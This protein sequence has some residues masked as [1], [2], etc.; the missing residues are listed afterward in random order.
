[1]DQP[2]PEVFHDLAAYSALASQSAPFD[3]MEKAIVAFAD[4]A[5]PSGERSHVGWVLVR[6]YPLTPAL[7][8]VT[9]VWARPDDERYVVAAKGAP[10]AI[11]EMCHLGTTTTTTYSG[12]A[13]ILDA[14]NTSNGYLDVISGSDQAY[15]DPL[16]LTAASSGSLGLSS[17][18]EVGGIVTAAQM[19]AFPLGWVV[20]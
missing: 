20:V 3:P 1:M 4:D 10:E 11:A 15:S 16:V 8:A 7:L 6:E 5:L 19:W 12:T 13:W 2:V 18:S 14:G 9:R 17:L